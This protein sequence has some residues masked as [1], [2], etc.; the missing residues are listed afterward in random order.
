MLNNMFGLEKTTIES[1]LQVFQHYPAIEKVLLYGSRAMGNYRPGSDI[2]LCVFGD[3]LSYPQLSQIETK[4]EALMLPYSI[5]LSLYHHI[6]NP[7]L[8]NHIQREGKIFYPM[9]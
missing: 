8:V 4:L 5:D 7:D 3:N 6:D 2:D 9:C 1:I